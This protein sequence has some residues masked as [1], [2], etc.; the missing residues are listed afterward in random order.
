MI[1]APYNFVPLNQEVFYP[2]WAEHVS[3]DVPFEDGESGVIEIEIESKSPIFIRDHENKEQ[4]CQ[5]NGQYY[6]PAT[7]VKGSI[8][9]VLEILSFSKLSDSLI[10]D[11]TYAVRDLR[12]RDL[13][14]SQMTPK[15]TFCGWLKKTDTSYVIEDCDIPGRIKHEEIDA[16]FNIKFA[17]NFK[18]QNFRNK[19]EFKSAVYKYRLLEGQNL[20]QM[21]DNGRDVQLKKVHTKGNVKQGTIVVT[22]QASGRKDRGKFD[23]KVYEFIFFASRRELPVSENIFENFKFAYFDSRKTEPKESPDWGFWKKKLSRGEKIPVFFQKDQ[24]GNVKHFGL[25][26]LYKLPY[27]HSVSEGIPQSHKSETLDLAETIFGYVSDTNALKGRVTFSHFHAINTPKPLPKRTEILGTPRASYY[28]MYVKQSG[29]NYKTYMNDGFELAGRKR[30]PIHNSQTPTATVSTG[31]DNIGTTFSPLPP[32]TVFKGKILYHNLKKEELGAILSALSFH[33][34]PSCFH[35]LGMAKSLGYGKSI[36]RIK[37]TIDTTS[38]LSAYERMISLTIPDWIT[39]KPV[40]ELL[41][42]ASEQNNQKSSLLKYM[43]LA[44]FADAKN[45]KEM[46]KPY[47][48]LDGIKKIIPVSAF[49][50]RTSPSEVKSSIPVNNTPSSNNVSTDGISKTKMRKALQESWNQ[51][52][53][54]FYHPKQIDE[55]IQGNF[56]TTPPEQAMVYTALKDNDAF[57]S[58]IQKIFDYNHD[59][60]DETQKQNLY[61]LILNF[62][63]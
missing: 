4:F 62:T 37:S 45:A 7:S 54:I 43:E 47:S 51:H 44:M 61:H 21:F 49:V 14:M 60:M 33:N 13:Y 31:N 30:Y 56:D 6:I 26:Y 8:R 32:K 34:T 5:H 42:M 55:F 15:N 40:S 50:E 17:S 1:T 53:K 58:L 19:P 25:S 16:I 20:T 23:A 3:H 57:C 27:A 9:S 41:T 36:F 11:S 63:L 48:Q 39:S 24:K 52:L 2:N 29:G 59:R 46:L 22:G 38:Y 18:Q 35:S 10:N 12:N 28:P